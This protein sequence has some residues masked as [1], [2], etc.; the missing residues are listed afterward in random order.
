MTRTKS[1][2]FATFAALLIGGLVIN[3]ASAAVKWSD[4]SAVTHSA[5]TATALPQV[6]GFDAFSRTD[7]SAVTHGAVPVEAKQVGRTSARNYSRSDVTAITHNQ[8]LTLPS[9]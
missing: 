2:I 6:G 7:V 5:G 8:G 3:P 9:G 1:S 4:I